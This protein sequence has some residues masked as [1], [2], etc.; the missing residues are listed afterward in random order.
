[1]SGLENHHKETIM[2]IGIAIGVVIACLLAGYAYIKEEP[3]KG[4]VKDNF[5]KNWAR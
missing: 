1:M 4:S 5:G 2:K 3:P